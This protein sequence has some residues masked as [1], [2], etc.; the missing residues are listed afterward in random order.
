MFGSTF[1][2]GGRTSSGST[3]RGAGLEVIG[4]DR[5]FIDRSKFGSNTV[6]GTGGALYLDRISQLTIQET[7]FDNNTARGSGGAIYL[8][9]S[10][11]TRNQ[12]A[13]ISIDRCNITGNTAASGGGI[14]AE[15]SAMVWIRAT[16]FE[17]NQAKVTVQTT[18]A[19]PTGADI[20]QDQPNRKSM[21]GSMQS[22]GA[23][24]AMLLIQQAAILS[25]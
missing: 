17:D 2:L 12:S 18:S 14:T 20:S 23:G 1:N 19:T 3:A 4:A 7:N 8:V 11:Q 10:G 22:G 13:S 9:D 5:V 16:V 21:L 25:R 24:G 15:A 6:E